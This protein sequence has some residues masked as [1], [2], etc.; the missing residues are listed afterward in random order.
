[1][2]ARSSAAQSS[3]RAAVQ[4]KGSKRIFFGKK[5][6]KNFY[7]SNGRSRGTLTPATA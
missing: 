7:F 3:K 2:A 1:L 6:A 5:E 4:G